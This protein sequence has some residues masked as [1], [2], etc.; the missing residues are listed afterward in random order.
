MTIMIK[1]R[2]P[3]PFCRVKRQSDISGGWVGKDVFIMMF[4]VTKWFQRRSYFE[5]KN[6][7]KYKK[8]QRTHVCFPFHHGSYSTCF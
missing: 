4:C 6:I 5:R 8:L 3:Y 1:G 2:R 7:N